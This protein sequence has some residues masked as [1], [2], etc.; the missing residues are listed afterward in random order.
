MHLLL[1][2]TSVFISRQ[3]LNTLIDHYCGRMAK[4]EIRGVTPSLI[5]P[6][7]GDSDGDGP[8]CCKNNPII[9]DLTNDEDKDNNH[10][11]IDNDVM[12]P[13]WE[14]YI[15]WTGITCGDLDRCYEAMD[16]SLFSLS[17]LGFNWA[18]N[19]KEPNQQIPPALF[20]NLK[21]SCMS[22]EGKERLEKPTEWLNDEN[23]NTFLNQ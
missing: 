4:T 20:K 7:E 18:P 6:D 8:H 19:G 14:L 1:A 17:R 16:K 3:T 21:A 11:E 2:P 10:N 5:P 9:E 13:G 12:G 23:V 22:Y 15:P